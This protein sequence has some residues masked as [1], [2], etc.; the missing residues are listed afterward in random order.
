MRTSSSLRLLTG[1]SLGALLAVS[2]GCASHADFIDLRAQMQDVARAQNQAQRQQDAIQR[3][4][5]ALEVA[6]T[7]RAVPSAEGSK[8][9]AAL[10]LQLDDLTAKLKD[11]EGRLARLEG[12]PLAVLPRPESTTGEPS[13]QSKPVRVPELQERGPVM[14]GTPDITPTSAY[15]LAYN[16]YLNGKYELAVTGF[17]RYLK[18]FPNSSQAPSAQYWLGESYY[19][20]KDYVR[21]IQAFERVVNQYPHSERVAPALFKMGMAAAETGDRPRARGLLKRVIEEYPTA[22]EAKLAKNKLAEI[23]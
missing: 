22:D 2:A 5:Q 11:L 13:R 6:P 12:P 23:R 8:E 20:L 19:N 1:T 18:D 4:L 3:R 15:N 7:P 17:Q 9:V 21:A 14:P 10:R 16:D